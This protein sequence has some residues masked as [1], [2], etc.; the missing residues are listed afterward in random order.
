LVGRVFFPLSLLER[1]PARVNDFT[2]E[3]LS[4]YVNFHR[5]CFFPRTV[6]DAKGRQRRLYRYEDMMTPFDKLASLTN[7][8]ERLKPGV[9]LAELRAVATAMS[10]STA[11]HQLNTARAALFEQISK[12]RKSA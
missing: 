1:Q 5:P 11:A 3:V 9:A 8:T 7:V 2:L 6:V 4:P 10:D 12:P